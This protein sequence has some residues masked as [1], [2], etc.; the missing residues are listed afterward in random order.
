LEA[1]LFLIGFTDQQVEAWLSA[2]RIPMCG[3][4]LSSGFRDAQFETA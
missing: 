2:D 4:D 1:V 3:A